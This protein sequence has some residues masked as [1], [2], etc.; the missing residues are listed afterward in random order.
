MTCR[1]SGCAFLLLVK[2]G[3]KPDENVADLRLLLLGPAAAPEAPVACS[4]AVPEGLSSVP[5]NSNGP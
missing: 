2:N 5:G 3:L 4:E 1:F